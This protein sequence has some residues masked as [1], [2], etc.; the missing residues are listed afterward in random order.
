VPWSFANELN[1]KY[2]LLL[3]YGKMFNQQWKKKKKKKKSFEMPRLSLIILL[4]NCLAHHKVFFALDFENINL[5][6]FLGF[7]SITFSFFPFSFLILHF[8]F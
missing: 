1:M 8:H 7:Q 2:F 5:F 3:E 6:F 4:I